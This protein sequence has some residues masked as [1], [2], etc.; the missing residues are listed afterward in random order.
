MGT[1]AITLKSASQSMKDNYPP[2]EIN[3]RWICLN[4]HGEV[5]RRLR[6]LALHPDTYKGMR[7]WIYCDEPAKFKMSYYGELKV[8]RE[9]NLRYVFHLEESN[10]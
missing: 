2:I 9:F 8:C 3:Q 6:I 7:Q 1:D 10:E 5:F 4:S